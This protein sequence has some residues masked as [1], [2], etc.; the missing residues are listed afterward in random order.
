MSE[1]NA[2]I[3]LSLTKALIACDRVLDSTLKYVNHLSEIT[4]GVKTMP[5]D[6]SNS[7]QF[8][9]ALAELDLHSLLVSVN[10]LFRYCSQYNNFKSKVP[11]DLAQ[12]IEIFRNNFEH[13]DENCVY[14]HAKKQN[15]FFPKKSAKSF[16]ELYQ[17]KSK[18]SPKGYISLDW[19]EIKGQFTPTIKFGGVLDISELKRFLV[20]ME[21]E[22]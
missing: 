1:S 16:I 21:S 17:T 11:P 7:H 22:I 5:E 13:W 19:K 14:F 3:K 8:L 10:Q 4:E 2:A 15:N 20:K 12:M 9:Y 6:W 18:E